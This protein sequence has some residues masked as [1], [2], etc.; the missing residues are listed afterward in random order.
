VIKAKLGKAEKKECR[1][2][3]GKLKGRDSSEAR[4]LKG[5]EGEIRGSRKE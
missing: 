3:Q 2:G 1:Q 5:D 4:K